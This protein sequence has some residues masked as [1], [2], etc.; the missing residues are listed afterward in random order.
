M[1]RLGLR[2][3][4]A[5]GSLRVAQRASGRM[6]LAL[7]HP[8][9]HARPRY[10]Y[11][12]PP[13]A[14]LLEIL[15]AGE[16]AYRGNLETIMG[17]REEL[18]AIALEKPGAGAP[19]WISNW[20]LGLDVASLYGLVRSRRP[21]R[22]VEIG[23]GI[24][25][26]WVHRALRDEGVR[27]TIT[28]IDPSP[29][30]E[31]SQLCDR[32]IRAPLETVDLSL[33]DELGPGDVVFMDGSHRVFT[34]SDATVFF[35]DVMPRLAPGVLVG[36]HDILL[37]DD[38]LPMWSDWYWSEQYLM[39]AYLLGGAN[40]IRMELACNYVSGHSDLRE[41][42]EPLWSAPGLEGVDRRGFAFWFTIR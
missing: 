23:S 39:A 14:A 41:M 30:T 37:P 2:D 26:A 22:Y 16:A 35:L 9:L 28:S 34:N 17:Y 20:L 36:V 27:A 40:G 8:P 25:T 19:P 3:L 7:D 4:V 15:R 13:H 24:S 6:L 42:L 11:G 29:R 38:Y 10:G 21:A 18:A 32:P 12:R 1:T 33:F 31:V 5:R